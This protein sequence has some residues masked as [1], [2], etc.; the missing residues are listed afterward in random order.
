MPS[1]CAALYRRELLEEVGLLDEEFFAY[2]EDSDLGLRG[3]WAGWKTA[4][5]PK[6]KVFHKYSASSST[7][8][9]LKLQLVE[10]NHYFLAIKN[11][12]LRLLLFLPLWTWYR[13][14]LM[15]VA[16][17]SGKG[18]GGAAQ[19]GQTLSLLGA[20]LR[21]H[22]QAFCG[23]PRQWRKARRIKQT[24]RLNAKAFAA[25]LKEYKIPIAT[26]FFTK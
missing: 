12:P 16:V 5:A 15:G 9:P 1:G 13:Y 10:R 11:Y 3:V 2:C 17:L 25:L 6:A 7:Y 8:S 22:W 18:K 20:F 4:S 19:K 14:L 23:I 21:G 26:L 24:R